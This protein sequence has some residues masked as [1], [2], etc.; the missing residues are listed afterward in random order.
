MKKITIDELNGRL[1]AGKIK[2]RLRSRLR[3]NP[4]G[5]KNWEDMEFISVFDQNHR[6]GV[7]LIENFDHS[8]VIP[9]SLTTGLTNKST[10]RS[11]AITCDFC[12]TWQIGKN[13]ASIT[14]I[15]PN[16]PNRTFGYLCCADLDCSSHVR[17]KTA[18]SVLSR[19]QL[20]EDLTID[21]RITR[22]KKNLIKIIDN[23]NI[24]P[25]LKN[26]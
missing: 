24:Q 14:I 20:R 13:A 7:I 23:A 19:T 18:E 8:Y 17:N 3:F 16:E 6:E 5:I 22:L 10:G 12:A 11:N 4:D 15:N 25:L 9:F 26:L 2:L 1:K 21:D